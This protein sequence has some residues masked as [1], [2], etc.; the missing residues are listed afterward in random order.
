VGTGLSNPKRHLGV[1]FAIWRSEDA[2]FWL[3]INPRGRGGMI[4]ATTNEV[5]AVREACLSIEEIQ[6]VS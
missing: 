5:Q 2:W 3:I 6:T 4:G 1:D